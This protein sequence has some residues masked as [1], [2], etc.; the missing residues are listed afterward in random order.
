MKTIIYTF[1]D[2]RPA[3]FERERFYLIK[4]RRQLDRLVSSLLEIDAVSLPL[5]CCEEP[6]KFPMLLELKAGFAPSL[7]L[8]KA[9]DISRAQKALAKLAKAAGEKS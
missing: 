4:S 9:S 5:E 2:G 7:S 6:K 8:A 1:K 3:F